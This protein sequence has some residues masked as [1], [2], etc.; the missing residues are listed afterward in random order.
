MKTRGLACQPTRYGQRRSA[1][2]DSA[3]APSMMSK[4]KVQ[5]RS[6]TQPVLSG[7]GAAAAVGVGHDVPWMNRRR[8][9]RPRQARLSC[10]GPGVSGSPGAGV[11]RTRIACSRD[12]ADTADGAFLCTSKALPPFFASSAPGNHCC[13]SDDRKRRPEAPGKHRGRTWSSCAPAARYE[14]PFTDPLRRWFDCLRQ[15]A[16]SELSS[17]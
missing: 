16:P 5:K 14:Q 12:D 1:S 6:R 15:I 11:V 10:I 7:I 3:P 8:D 17:R 13:R 4:D 9:E 2:A